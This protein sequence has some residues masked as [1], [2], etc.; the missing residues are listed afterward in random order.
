MKYWKKEHISLL[1]FRM[2]ESILPIGGLPA[3]RGMLIEFDIPKMLIEV[4]IVPNT[5]QDADISNQLTG[6]IVRM[7]CVEVETR[8]RGME[9]NAI[10]TKRWELVPFT[11]LRISRVPS[12]WKVDP[13]DA[14]AR[15]MKV[16]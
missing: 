4:E 14:Y 11:S 9:Y 1:D 6:D 16:I 15:A 7:Y 3:R 13:I 2:G 8:R 10:W 12:G 5:E